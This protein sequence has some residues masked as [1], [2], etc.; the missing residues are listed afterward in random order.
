[1]GSCSYSEQRQTSSETILKNSWG[2]GSR[3]MVK[4]EMGRKSR[5]EGEKS[6]QEQKE[7]LAL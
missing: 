3:M 2:R 6:G 1:M 5:H 4:Q 7:C